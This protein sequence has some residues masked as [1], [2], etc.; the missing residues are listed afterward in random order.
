MD[1]GAVRRN[2]NK[3]VESC[4]HFMK[5]GQ[6]KAKPRLWHSCHSRKGK[7]LTGI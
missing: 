4:W 2:V 5:T 1:R 3:D 7:L 6:L